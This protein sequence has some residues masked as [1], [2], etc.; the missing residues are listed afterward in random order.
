M[1]RT[2]RAH[3]NARLMAQLRTAVG[4]E[5]ADLV[6]ALTLQ[7]MD[8]AR[9]M[10]R[11]FARRGAALDDLEQV[12][13]LALF[14][15]ACDFDDERGEHFMPWAV[16]CVRGALRHY[17]RDEAWIVRPPRSV[18]S[19]HYATRR[20]GADY[21]AGGINVESCLRPTHVDPLIELADV[22]AATPAGTAPATDP[23]NRVE[24]REY[25]RPY[26]AALPPR[27]RRLL[28]LRYVHERTQYEIAA[29]LGLSQMQVSRLLR[30]HLEEL[31][32]AMS[33]AAA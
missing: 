27:A 14:R 31:R 25:L 24:L 11:R 20:A 30:R 7:N 5:R 29:E 3:A 23:F 8:V 32:A 6:E 1:D 13:Y 18:Q 2:E 19:V 10:T 33:V 21:V 26:L 15:A 22:T 12:A 17:F 9:S 28:H 4:A 16:A